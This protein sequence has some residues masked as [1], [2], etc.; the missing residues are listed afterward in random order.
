MRIVWDVETYPNCFTLAA[1]HVDYPM[2]W[3]FEISEF[4]DD[5]KQLMEWLFWLQGQDAQMVGF[6]NVGFDYPVLHHF[7]RM[8]GRA[9]STDLYNKAMQIIS[10]R[11]DED[12]FAHIV[13]PS[14]RVVAQIDLFRIHHF[15]NFAKATSLKALEFNMR[16]D[17]VE[18]L[19]FPVGTRLTP[20]QITVLKT[21]NQ[22]DVHATKVF[23]HHT[24]PM[25]QFR[26]EL[27]AKHGKDF[28]N[29]N[30]TKIGSEIFQMELEKAEIPCYQFIGGTRMPRQTLRP[31]I[32]LAECIPPWVRFDHAAFQRVLDH[33]RQQVITETKGVFTD[34]KAVVGGVEFFFGT[35]GIHGS[36]DREIVTEGAEWVIIDLDVISM[37]TSIAI[38]QGYYPEHLTPKFVEVY[39]Q[40]KDQRVHYKKGSPEN[41]MLKLAL[42]GV[43]GKSNDKFSIFF[44]P[45]FTMSVTLT[46]QLA[47]A[48]LIEK[49]AVISH[50]IQ[51]NT[52]GVT[53]KV[54]RDL[55][56]AVHGITQEWERTTGLQLEE[57]RYSR[58]FIRDVNSYIAEYEDGHVKRKGAYEWDVEWHQNA[59][60]LVVPKVAEKVLLE[61]AP[62]RETVENWPDKMDFM[63]R[64][65][66]PRSSKLVGDGRELPNM[67]RYYISTEGVTLT[68]IMPPL[69]KKP[70]VW[71]NFSVEAGW[72]VC[73]CNDIRN[74]TL[75]ID[76]NYYVNEVEKITLGLK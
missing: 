45:K 58:M 6:N 16:L 2:T 7:W 33:L 76:F 26:E 36:V 59:S 57:A 53:I 28:L 12:K 61:G 70:G 63:L 65:K 55:I 30:D 52:D 21:Y 72:K 49:L 54:E 48:M 41:A 62:I 8:L 60:A 9:T 3:M 14:D 34:L 4:R 39:Q 29:H 74:A 66:V 25:I 10:S 11:N 67:L 44:D 64:V 20:D 38:S 75:P 13:Y 18:D 27:S 37:Y 1:E 46:G 68:K 47:M 73:P 43:Y 5:S 35:G 69:A 17:N 24:L 56:G 50:I 71:R 31:V 15:D 32:R 19:P 22:H 23:Y 40:V 42:N 51:A